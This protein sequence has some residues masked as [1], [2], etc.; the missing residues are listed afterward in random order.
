MFST[1]K[2]M[3]RRAP[4]VVS[5][6]ITVSGPAVTYEGVMIKATGGLSESVAQ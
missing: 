1:H 6:H 5:R 3:I 4:N 2:E